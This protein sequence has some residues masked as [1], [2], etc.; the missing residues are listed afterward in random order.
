MNIDQWRSEVLTAVGNGRR[1]AGLFGTDVDG[2]LRLTALLARAGGID[3]LDVV[4]PAGSKGYPALSRDLQAAFWYERELHDLFGVVPEAHPRLDPLVLPVT[5]GSRPRPGA[6]DGPSRLVPDEAM[7]PRLILGEGLFT[8]PHGPVRSGI[9]ESIEYLIETP[10]EDVLHPQIRVFAK[11]RGL[12]KRFERMPVADAILLAERVEG[13]ASVAHALA[14][15]HAVEA[16]AGVSVPPPAGAVRVLHAEL[17]R[18]ANHLDTALRLAE[19]AG[20]AV[21]VARF[22]WHKER[23]MRV[24]SSLCGNRF[25]RGV[26][27]P[28]GVAG[29]PRLPV[30]EIRAALHDLETAISGDEREL[31]GTSTFLD[32]LRGTG[33]LRPALAAEHGALGPIGRA[34]G[35]VDDARTT[36]PYD[37][38]AHLPAPDVPGLSDGDALA[39]LRVRFAELHA[40]FGLAR[41]ALVAISGDIDT[42]AFDLP[43]GRGIGWAEAPQGEVVYVVEVAGGRI[44][45]CKPRSASFHN[46]VL[47]HSVFAGEILTD[48]PFIEASFGLS[49]AGVAL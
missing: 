20:L 11:H 19:A 17:E 18:I 12:E 29:P 21:A 45:R 44:R 1:F 16:M 42:P 15:A 37:A 38:Y 34:S 9:F 24:V 13:I 48:F 14:F 5:N 22:G 3:R 36:R 47:F 25:G 49:P 41:A 2:D 32:R 35:V 30:A 4:L 6:E 7:L 23:V 43:D 39:R 28:G 10:G 26:V 31:M 46:Q 40:A 27:V 33:P 8:I